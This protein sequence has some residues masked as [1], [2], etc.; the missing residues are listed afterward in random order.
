MNSELHNY[1]VMKT[2]VSETDA[3]A[4]KSLML[5]L[6]QSLWSKSHF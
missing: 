6:F 5:C 2:A 1:L 4:P 3:F